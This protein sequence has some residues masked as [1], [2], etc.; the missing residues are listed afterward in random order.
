MDRYTV[1]DDV[2]RDLVDIGLSALEAEVYVVL[3]AH[4]VSTG[5]RVGQL[6]NKPTANVYKA[7][8]ALGHK[9]AV[10]IEDG[11]ARAC[12]AVPPEEFLRQVESAVRQRTQHIAARLAHI[13]PAPP[14]EHIY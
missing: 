11:D 6:L 13:S 7:L 10:M 8:E 9:G 5:Y 2:V 1:P 12:R 4:P 3:L 14:D